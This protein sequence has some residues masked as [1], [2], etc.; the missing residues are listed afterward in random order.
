MAPTNRKSTTAKPAPVKGAG[1][2]VP[3]PASTEPGTPTNPAPDTTTGVPPVTPTRDTQVPAHLL[4]EPLPDAPTPTAPRTTTT[5]G[6]A[7]VNPY[8]TPLPTT[9]TVATEP[10]AVGSPHPASTA[11]T[12]MP[13]GPDAAALQRLARLGGA[14]PVTPYP[15]NIPAP[16]PT[17]PVRPGPAHVWMPDET[18]TPATVT[19]LYDGWRVRI[20]DGYYFATKGETV[21]LPRDIAVKAANRG[22]VHLHPTTPTDTDT[23]KDA[24]GDTDG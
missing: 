19:V 21:T 11:D 1:S 16:D 23:E 10:V 22:T 2:P 14:D 5:P 15:G 18:A 8:V 6:A 3:Q 7:P 13:A 12:T 24:G 17:I 4:T 20:G 9:R